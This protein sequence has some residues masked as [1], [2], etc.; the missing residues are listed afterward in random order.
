MIH[1]IVNGSGP[2]VILIHGL[3]ASLKNWHSL[4]PAI[5]SHGYRTWALDLPGH[6]DSQ[7]PEDPEFY[8]NG[9]FLTAIDDWLADLPDNPPFILV[10]HSLGGYISLRFAL[11]HPELVRTL[12]LINPLFSQNHI[13]SLMRSIERL[14]GLGALN[15]FAMHQ[16]PNAAIQ[17]FLGLGPLNQDRL[18]PAQLLQI[19][20][21]YKR[22]SPHLLRLITTLPDL[23][24]FLSSIHTPCLVIWGD[25][26]LTLDPVSFPLLVSLMPD[27]QGHMIPGCGHQPHLGRPDL[28]NPLV[29]RF[30]QGHSECID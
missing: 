4:K 2:P 23:K 30:I 13:S 3:A 17:L 19:A 16:A 28:V 27:A 24:P 5:A 11:L 18:S 12:V 15:V 7:K 29:T 22:T 1:S 9:D 26:D 14:P 25:K 21:D 20:D 6:G 10:G 8:S